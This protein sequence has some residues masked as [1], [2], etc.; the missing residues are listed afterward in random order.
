[1]ALT[2]EK[3]HWYFIKTPWW[4]KKLFRQFTWEMPANGKTLYLTF[5]DGPHPSITPWV[6]AELKKW[7][8]K[9]TFFCIGKNVL[10]YP[11]VYNTILESG[12]TTGNHTF[13]HLN[14]WKVSTDEYIADIQQATSLIQSCLFR[15]PYGRI[16]NKHLQPLKKL[17]GPH[18]Q[19]VM[20][21]V[22][23]ADFDKSITKEQCFN[24]ILRNVKDGSV[25]VLH[26]SEKAYQNLSYSLPLVL[27]HLSAKGYVFKSLK[28]QQ[29][30]SVNN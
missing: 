12:H 15:P 29:S 16:K 28:N 10:Q 5:D 7:N 27:Q 21:D 1:M 19:V 26:D 17:L 13:S 25:I 14:G 4:V 30:R 23:S 20:W 9:A 2:F 18:A 6:L 22:L 24:N 11:R 8:A 3:M